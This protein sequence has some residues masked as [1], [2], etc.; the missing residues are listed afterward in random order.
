MERQIAFFFVFLLFAANSFA[1]KAATTFAEG[2]EGLSY[3]KIVISKD[4]TN[5]NLRKEMIKRGWD[6]ESI[7]DVRVT[8]KRGVLVYSESPMSPAFKISIQSELFPSSSTRVSSLDAMN[9]LIIGWAVRRI[10]GSS[11]SGCCDSCWRS[12]ER[13]LKFR[14]VDIKVVDFKV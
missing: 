2:S 3:E 9:S 7:F 5:F 8:I 4:T 13:R 1:Q 6:G 11:R 14:F 10:L 12:R